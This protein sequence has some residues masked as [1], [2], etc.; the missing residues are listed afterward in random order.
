MI[1]QNI[2]AEIKDLNILFFLLIRT[3]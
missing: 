1:T 3:Y 2:F